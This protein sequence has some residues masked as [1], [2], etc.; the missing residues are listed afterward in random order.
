MLTHLIEPLIGIQHPFPTL[1][2]V[3]TKSVFFALRSPKSSPSPSLLPRSSCFLAPAD[4][5]EPGSLHKNASLYPGAV[6]PEND[7]DGTE[8]LLVKTVKSIGRIELINS[9][10]SLYAGKC[11]TE[12]INHGAKIKKNC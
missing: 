11:N 8:I 3:F 6:Y 4:P 10:E 1:P 5:S 2:H 12:L 7:Q 9:V